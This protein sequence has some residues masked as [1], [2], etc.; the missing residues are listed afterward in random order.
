MRSL[1]PD[2]RRQFAETILANTRRMQRIV[3][4]LLDLLGSNPADGSRSPAPVDV[5]AAAADAVVPSRDT[6]AEK[7]VAARGVAYPT[8]PGP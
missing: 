2:Q 3:D 6:A 7:G 4:D 5:R 1:P 8:M